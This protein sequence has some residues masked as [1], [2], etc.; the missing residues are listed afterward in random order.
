MR[1]AVVYDKI[2]LKRLLMML[3]AIYCSHRES[4]SDTICDDCPDN[5]RKQRVLYRCV[6]DKLPHS[7][8]P[9]A[10]TVKTGR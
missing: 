2:E 4:Y 9:G 7:G 3:W 10:G 5:V 6:P 1:C 8:R